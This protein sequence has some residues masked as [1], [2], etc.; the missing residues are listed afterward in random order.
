MKR[1]IA[2]LTMLVTTPVAVFA[3]AAPQRPVG[4]TDQPCPAAP[5]DRGTLTPRLARL[6]EPGSALLPPDPERA[7]ANQRAEAERLA[8]DWAQLCRYDAENRELAPPAGDEQRVV[9]MGDSITEFWK[10]ADPALFSSGVIDRGIS[11]QTTGQMLVRFRQ[12]VIDLQPVA[13]HLMAGTND[14]AGNS[15]PTTL[16]A[17]QANIQSMVDLADAHGIEVILASIPPA[18][19]FPWRAGLDPAPTIALLNAWLQGYAAGKGLRYVDYH[20]VLADEASGLKKPLANDGVHP[21]RDGYALM[22]PLA[23]SAIAAARRG[24]GL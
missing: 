12:D 6:L 1:M 8:T 13:V 2:V 24:K 17:V 14:I 20:A 21:N 5:A 23:E 9:F 4:I 3:A 19:A 22:R 18:A 15:G 10:L 7:A 11:G 16:E